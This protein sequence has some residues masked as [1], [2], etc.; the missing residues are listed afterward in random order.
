M[1]GYEIEFEF[2]G[3]PQEA[4]MAMLMMQLM[5]RHAEIIH[6]EEEAPQMPMLPG[7]FPGMMPM[8]PAQPQHRLLNGQKPKGPTD[9]VQK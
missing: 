8:F 4:P 6:F 1:E 7:M 9:E 5:M 3:D 2:E